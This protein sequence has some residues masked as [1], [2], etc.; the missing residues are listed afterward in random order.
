MKSKSSNPRINR[1]ALSLLAMLA[2]PMP[3]LAASPEYDIISCGTREAIREST[4]FKT[5][6][7][8]EETNFGS[9][10]L[11]V[12]E[13]YFPPGYRTNAHTHRSDEVFYVIEG[14]FGHFVNGEGRMLRPGEIGVARI[15]D[16]VEHVTNEDSSARVLVMWVPG[17]ELPSV[18]ED[19]RQ[20]WE[21]LSCP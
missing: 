6:V 4:G 13:M 14:V 16:S 15:G 11:Q 5:R 18:E 9:G 20:T 17:G 8:L 12:A 10:E 3:A 21:M 7:L 2:V 19:T 1:W